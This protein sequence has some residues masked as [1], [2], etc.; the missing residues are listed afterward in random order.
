MCAKE[1]GRD[2]AAPRRWGVRWALEESRSGGAQKISGMRGEVVMETHRVGRCQ[3]PRGRVWG[4]PQDRRAAE[5]DQRGSEEAAQ[6]AQPGG[7]GAAGGTSGFRSSAEGVEGK[8]GSEAGGAAEA[9][10]LRHGKRTWVGGRQRC[11]GGGWEALLPRPALSHVLSHG[12]QGS[13]EKLLCPSPASSFLF[14]QTK[15][16]DDGT[17]QTATMTAS[18]LYPASDLC[19]RRLTPD[20]AAGYL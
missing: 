2:R 7:E 14:K 13:S 18:S 17:S 5:S 9:C 12:T 4:G 19:G 3:S 10:S 20:P 8:R 6:E 1:R 16:C 11:G 15:P